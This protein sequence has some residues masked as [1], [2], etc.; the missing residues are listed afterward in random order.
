[1]GKPAPKGNKFAVKLKDPAIRQK[2]YMDMCNWISHGK[3]Y[4]SFIFYHDA[5]RMT[6]E[7]IEEMSRNHPTEFDP[8]EK[9]I[10][11]AMKF[12]HWEKILEET[13]TGE[14]PHG[15]TATLQMIFRNIFGWDK[16]DGSGHSEVDKERFKFLGDWMD[17][18]FANARA[19]EDAKK[20]A[21]EKQ[22]A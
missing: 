2:A 16:K 4:K 14:N 1:M 20:K 10:A 12:R 3:S 7:A 22:A 15:N 18:A 17:K 9:E 5:I 6:G 21:Q 19:A 8:L 13:A 11:H